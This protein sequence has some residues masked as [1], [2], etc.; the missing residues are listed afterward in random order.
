MGFQQL[1]EAHSE[2][3]RGLIRVSE[4]ESHRVWAKAAWLY[5]ALYTRWL[6]RVTR[7][8][9]AWRCTSKYIKG[10]NFE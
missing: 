8:P 4:N 2:L 7:I 10:L 9:V 1:H 5:V 6:S 3:L